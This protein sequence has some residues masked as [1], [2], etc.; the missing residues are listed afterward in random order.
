MAKKQLSFE[1][2]MERLR[3][4]AE[5]LERGSVT[6]EESVRLFSEGASLSARCY[7]ALQAA[8]QKITELSVLPSDA[9]E[10]K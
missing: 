3:A 8:E 6:L 1:E 10:V 9:E 4:I 2:S 7:E 5:E